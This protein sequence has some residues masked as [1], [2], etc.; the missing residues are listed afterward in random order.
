M[1]RPNPVPL[2]RLAAAARA[3]ASRTVSRVVRCRALIP[4]LLLVGAPA[5]V[6]A[7]TPA[8]RPQAAPASPAARLDALAEEYW[9]RLVD[10]APALRLKEGL[11]VTRLPDVSHGHA[12]AEAEWARGFLE[13]LEAIDPAAFDEAGDAE[14]RLTHRVLAWQAR[15]IVDALPHFWHRF[16]VTPYSNGL[17]TLA[18]VFSSAPLGTPEERERFLGLL[19]EVARLARQLR[20]VL[21]GQRERG[22]LLPK[23]EIPLVRATYAPLAGAPAGH[24]YR[25]AP[26]RLSADATGL[27]PEAA[28]GF[29]RRVDEALAERVAPAFAGLLAVLDDE[30]RAA[31]PEEVGLGRQPGGDA[32]YRFLVAHHTTVDG[33]SPEEIHERG[34]AEVE[35]IEAEMA[36][37]RELLGAEGV[38]AREFHD[39]LRTDP[40]FL[41]CD[42]E[43]VGERLMRAIRRIEPLVEDWF[44]E[45]PAA[46]YGVARLDPALE[47]G[48]TFGYYQ[49]PTPAEP[50]GRYYFNGSDLDQRPLVTA[51]ALIYHELVPGHHFQIALQ[52]QNEDL[53]AFRRNAFPTAFV[54]GWAEYASDVA[55]EMGLYGDPY[56]RY[57]RLAMD[58]FLSSRLVVDTGM[59]ALGWSR[60]RALEFLRDRVLESDTQLATETLR[61]SVDIPGQALAYKVGALAIQDLRRRAEEALGE[62][63]DVRRFHQAVLDHG[64]LPLAVLE[65]HVEWWIEEERAR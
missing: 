27:S 22:I 65:E 49:W 58:M 64:A 19:D 30:Y 54:E 15:Q 16:Q 48:M 56:D 2:A 29:A 59:N 60:E 18:Q 57:G 36:E 50:T 33:L 28:E 46:P 44:L 62:E 40:R 8:Q 26:E 35:R 34:L 53:P 37:I 41:A 6:R 51:A 5:L 31:A 11:P 4:A 7:A 52:T 39:R 21:E 3:F 17:N 9:Q 23:P 20:E 61:Y 47:G 63:F 32:A 12:E 1:N 13:R 55:G 10:E 14:R 42:P 24:P 43:E 38:T 45:T 25:P